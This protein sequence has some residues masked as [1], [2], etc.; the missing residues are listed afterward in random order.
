MYYRTLVR[1]QFCKID[2]SMLGGIAMDE[3]N[4]L[5]QEISHLVMESTDYEMLDLVHKLLHGSQ[6]T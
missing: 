4:T 3:L 1:K 6:H 2:Y 5:K